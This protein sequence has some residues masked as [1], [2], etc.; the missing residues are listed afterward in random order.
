M[1]NK[2]QPNTHNFKKEKAGFLPLY[3]S[4]L[5]P[6]KTYVNEKGYMKDAPALLVDKLKDQLSQPAPSTHI[7]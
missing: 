2:N 3:T 1:Y 5:E 6:D 4:S 7:L